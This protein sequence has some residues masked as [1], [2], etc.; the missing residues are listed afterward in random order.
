MKP[1]DVATVLTRNPA[2]KQRFQLKSEGAGEMSH[3]DSPAGAQEA[4]RVQRNDYG[5]LRSHC[6]TLTYTQRC[7]NA[8]TDGSTRC[9]EYCML[10][11][12]QP[13]RRNI[14]RRHMAAVDHFFL[15]SSFG[16]AGETPP[17]ERRSNRLQ[18]MQCHDSDPSRLSRYALKATCYARCAPLLLQ[19]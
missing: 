8:V 7:S 2:W 16:S 11:L 15:R 6:L 1:T 19:R 3:R 10:H 12:Q 4:A 18:C 5:P 9:T 17:K 14:R 13:C